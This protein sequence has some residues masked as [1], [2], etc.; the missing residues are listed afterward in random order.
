M[1]KTAQD[2]QVVRKKQIETKV[3]LRRGGVG[4]TCVELGVEVNGELPFKGGIG[5]LDG[6]PHPFLQKY[7]IIHFFYFKD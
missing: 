6:G 7:Y 1:T 4:G 5:I 2:D 3:H